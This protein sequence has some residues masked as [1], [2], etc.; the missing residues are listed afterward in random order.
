[1][2]PSPLGHAKRWASE[3]QEKLFCKS[4]SSSARVPHGSGVTWEDSGGLGIVEAEYESDCNDHK[5][6]K[7]RRQVP[8]THPKRGWK[9]TF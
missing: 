6:M 1:M 2:S 7:K 3:L 8:S 4:K 5:Q 9:V